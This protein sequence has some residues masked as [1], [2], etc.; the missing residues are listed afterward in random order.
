MPTFEGVKNGLKYDSETVFGYSR[1]CGVFPYTIRGSEIELCMKSL[2]SCIVTLIAAVLNIINYDVFE[3]AVSESV[4][5]NV[6]Y[7]AMNVPC[8]ISFSMPIF[9]IFW[10]KYKS[11][12]LVR[13]FRLLATIERVTS[14]RRESNLFRILFSYLM[15]YFSF[16]Y[17]FEFFYQYLPLLK[18]SFFYVNITQIYLVLFQFTSLTDAI[19][20]HYYDL[21]ESLNEANAERRVRIHEALLECSVCLSLC[22]SPQLMMAVLASFSYSTLNILMLIASPDMRNDIIELFYILSWYIF[23]LSTTWYIVFCCQ[24]AIR[25]VNVFFLDYV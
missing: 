4:Q 5:R 9:S 1:C 25:Q 20:F 18:N 13:V 24:D 17:M 21:S 23:Q 14:R 2:L 7:F 16:C 22:Y 3:G 6:F 19:K 12:A 15:C 8:H 11:K 10:L